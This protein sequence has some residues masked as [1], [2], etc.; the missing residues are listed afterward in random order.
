MSGTTEKTPSKRLVFR[1]AEE[2]ASAIGVSARHLEDNRDQWG[3]PYKRL[4]GR[5]VYPIK[6]MEKWVNTPDGRKATNGEPD[7]D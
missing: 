3:V 2:A 1:D 7:K 5:I 4:G 6:A